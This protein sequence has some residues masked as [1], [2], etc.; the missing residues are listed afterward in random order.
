[1][2]WG[3]GKI[4]RKHLANCVG[5][6][7]MGK[8]ELLAN[9]PSSSRVLSPFGY[10]PSISQSGACCTPR[11][12]KGLSIPRPEHPPFW[13]HSQPQGKVQRE[14]RPLKEEEEEER[15]REGTRRR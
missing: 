3:W 1:M 14:K 8:P 10:V 9:P 11:W 4:L 12:D 13:G 6:D 2:V 15:G 5:L 7:E